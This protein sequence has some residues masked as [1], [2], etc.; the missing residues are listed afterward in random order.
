MESTA[1]KK[2]KLVALTAASTR[3]AEV[4]ALLADTRAAWERARA[5]VVLA[6]TRLR[7]ETADVERL[8]KKNLPNLLLTVTGNMESKRAAEI[9]EADEAMALYE[10]AHT[11]AAELHTQVLS[12][13][14]ELRSLGNCDKELE[15]LAAAVTAE[16][17]AR[18]GELAA[19]IKEVKAR[20]EKNA[21]EAKELNELVAVGNRLIEGIDN[22][23]PSLRKARISYDYRYGS[24]KNGRGLLVSKMSLNEDLDRGEGYLPMLIAL[25]KSFRTDLV[26]LPPVGQLQALQNTFRG[27]YGGSAADQLDNA[28]AEVETAKTTVTRSMDKLRRIQAKRE[29]ARD[30]ARTEW[31]DALTR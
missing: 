2:E 10:A 31:L 5:E 23:L 12:L 30:K 19:E 15:A 4:Q 14:S 28:I 25:A 16:V 3:K 24:P 6:E 11:R 9:A 1:S 27:T 22:I 17:S 7:S 26:D 20:M 8:D 18:G 21:A 29:E 13:E